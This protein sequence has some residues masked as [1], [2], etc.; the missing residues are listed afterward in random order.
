MVIIIIRFLLLLCCQACSCVK[1]EENNI[2]ILNSIVPS[3]LPIFPSSLEE[4]ENDKQVN[5]SC[6][7]SPHP[8]LT[9][10]MNLAVKITPIGHHTA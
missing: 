7:T 5:V 6:V 2:A 10:E 3:L 4:G 1:F 9:Q 8:N